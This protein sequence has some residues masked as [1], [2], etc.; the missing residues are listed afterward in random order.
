MTPIWRA[1]GIALGEAGVAGDVVSLSV[2]RTAPDALA[3]EIG[4]VAMARHALREVLGETL[5]V[6]LV[7]HP[8]AGPAVAPHVREGRAR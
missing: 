8:A 3:S 2:A 1:Q 6:E 7:G 4:A 5:R